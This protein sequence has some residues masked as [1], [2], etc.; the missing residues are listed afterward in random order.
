MSK[1][2]LKLCVAGALCAAGVAAAQAPNVYRVSPEGRDFALNADEGQCRLHIWI[3]ER[4][5]VKLRGDQ[6]IVDTRAGRQSFDQ[7]SVCNQPLPLHRVENFRVTLAQGRGRVVDV[8]SPNPRNEFSGSVTVEDPQRGGDSY[9]LIMA[10]RNPEGFRAPPLAA[11]EPSPYFD[12]TRACQE[13][14]RHQFLT[15]NTDGDAYVEF[16]GFTDRDDMGPNR[17]RI[18]GEE[19]A[20]NASESRRMSYECLLN[21]RTNR[22]LSASYDLLGP[23]RYSSLY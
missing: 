9:E 3:D 8:N 23:R 22:V 19:I 4:A 15:N 20:R 16:N 1:S 6:I 21:D 7:G 17:E 12:E 11:N 2:F 13:R 14:V 5:Q 10:W 18:R